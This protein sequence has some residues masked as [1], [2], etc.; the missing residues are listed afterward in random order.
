L[1][2]APLPCTPAAMAT[3]TAVLV[4]H[5]QNDV[6]HPDG[7]IRVGLSAEDPARQQVIEAARELIAGARRLNLP[8]IHIRI[9]FRPDYADLIQNCWIFR[10]TAEIGAVQEGSW[11]AAFYEGLE[12][13]ERRTNE[14]VIRHQRT[15]GFIGTPLEQL[16]G[17]LGARQLIVAG[18]STHSVVEMTVRHASDLGFEV[19]VAANACAAAERRIHDA[20]LD[21]MRLIADVSTVREALRAREVVA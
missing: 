20:S 1:S 21:N 12:P 9:A 2:A 5:Y 13:D 16:L 10:K 6:L 8:L 18:V 14:F 3:A 19:T 7:R 17:K 15:S 11:G 4:L